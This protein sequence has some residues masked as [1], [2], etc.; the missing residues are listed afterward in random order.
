MLLSTSKLSSSASSGSGSRSTSGISTPQ[1]SIWSR[2]QSLASCSKSH[3]P[4]PALSLMVYA[5][6]ASTGVPAGMI[7]QIVSL[8][9]SSF[10]ARYR[11]FPPMITY[12]PSCSKTS[13]SRR[14][15]ISGL[16]WRL[17][18]SFLY[19]SSRM[20]RGFP[21]R[22]GI[23]PLFTSMSDSL[24]MVLCTTSIPGCYSLKR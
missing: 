8:Y 3:S 23:C 6:S 11:M 9:P 22:P 7:L 19:F 16:S 2:S 14:A 4:N 15:V 1:L 10:I 21:G 24:M 12:F 13:S 5:L 20:K 18:I 17:L